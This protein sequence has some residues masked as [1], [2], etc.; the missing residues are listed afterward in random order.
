MPSLINKMF[1][2]ILRVSSFIFLSVF[3]VSSNLFSNVY[4]AQAIQ[5]N[6]IEKGE[7][8]MAIIIEESN[9]L[10]DGSNTSIIPDLGDEQA[11]PFIPGFG[12]NSGK[13]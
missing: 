4:P 13:D 6:S 9:E 11:F 1:K 5:M 12:K 10:I 7:S 3:L 8:K 2:R